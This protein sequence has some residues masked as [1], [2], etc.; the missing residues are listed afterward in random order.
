MTNPLRRVAEMFTSQF[1]WL[2]ISG[3]RSTMRIVGNSFWPRSHPISE[4]TVVNYD[5]CRSLYKNNGPNGYGAAFAKP[6]IDL[7]VGFMGL[8]RISTGN[9]ANDLFLNECIQDYWTDELQQMFRDAMRDSK[10]IVRVCRPDVLDPLMTLNEADHCKIELL[11]PERVDLQY[12]FRNK[13][14]L[15]QA[16]ILHRMIIVKDPGNPAEGRDPI[17]EEHEVLEIITRD[18][19]R[20][21]DQNTNEYLSDMETPNVYDFVPLFECD[22]EWDAAQQGG[23]SDLE[24]VIPFINAFHDVVTQGLQ[25]HRYHSTP[26]IKLKIQDIA[27]FIRNNFP[28]AW[29]QETGTIKPQTEISWKGREV[30]LMQSEEDAQFLEATS[31]LGDTK[32]LAEF[33][34]DCICI[35]SQTPEWAFMRVDSGSANSDR[36]A[37]TVPFVKKI[38]RK[39]RNFTKA[40]QMICKMVLVMN[41]NI[42][43][44]ASVSWDTPRPDDQLIEAQA[45]QQIVM[46]LEAAKASGEISEE[47][48]A[49]MI[50]MFIPMMKD[51]AKEVSQGKAD[52]KAA[53]AAL[54]PAPVPV[55]GGPQGR[56]E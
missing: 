19:Y 34:L 55:V 16:T 23:S 44:R 42:P 24:P 3:I 22:N 21:F 6:I 30:L 40:I 26:K 31:V 25:A 20:F 18:R 35:A 9:D 33:L 28:Q 37:Q 7:P 39:R 17:E 10:T 2:S 51:P 45:F 1:Q 41:G 8:P 43:Y 27:T 4:G 54:P 47:T 14:I 48:Y 36:N 15:E 50:A 12:N 32:V 29:D 46:G 38:D 13:N 11:P 49:K 56:N 53:Q 5:Y 52:L